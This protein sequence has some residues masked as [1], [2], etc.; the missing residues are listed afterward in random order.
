LS[1][2]PRV[3]IVMPSLNQARFLRAA[4]D[5]VLTQAY[6]NLEVLVMDGGSTD[7]SVDIL[8]GYGDRI[9]FVSEPD[10]GQSDAINRGFARATGQFLAW[11][12]SDD[13]YLPGAVH[14][15]CEALAG[16]SQAVMVYG[17]GE[18]IDDSGRVLG[19][20][21]HTQPFDLWILTHLSDFI[22]QP[23]VFMR[24]D[25]VRSVGGLDETLHFGMD[26]DLWIRLACLGRV[27]HLRETLAQTRE[28][29][30]TKTTTGGWRRLREIRA[31]MERH[32]ARDWP[33]GARAYGLDT[34]RHLSPV[35]FGPASLA[36]AESL[37]GQILPRLFR[38]LH[39]WLAEL[40]A[41]QT[42]PYPGVWPDGWMGPRAFRALPWSGQ[43]GTLRAELD[44]P[45]Q[46]VPFTLEVAAAGG[47]VHVERAAP[48]PFE[49]LLPLP[50]APGRPRPL[51]V[52][53]RAS[54]N[55]QAPGDRRK[56][57]CLLRNL[58]FD[59]ANAQPGS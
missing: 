20:F 13:R 6:P 56:L 53:F 21:I 37:R 7:G 27:V 9:S 38:P 8:R 30:Q 23:T 28:H 34:L 46:L 52:A 33:P 19:P 29:A 44:A 50:A 18:I 42:M 11:L 17:E 51:E 45:V 48:G 12:N 24:A 15:A 26:W 47:R 3:S 31:I 43:A 2:F 32:G 1:Q 4:L 5:S 39:T 41:R 40:I 10:R 59:P 16:A 57:S 36:A 55:W 49:V 54:R 58:A 25:A 14:K 22:M 35:I